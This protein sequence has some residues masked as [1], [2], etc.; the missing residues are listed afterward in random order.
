[1]LLNSLKK[2]YKKNK[3]IIL[4]KYIKSSISNRKIIIR[5]ALINSWMKTL[6]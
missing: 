4:T 5:K 1:M 3:P 6:L 2:Y